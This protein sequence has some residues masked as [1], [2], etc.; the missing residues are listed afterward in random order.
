MAKVA[1]NA[2]FSASM[3]NG[4][5]ADACAPA[6]NAAAVSAMIAA[7]FN[8]QRLPARIDAGRV[9]REGF[10]HSL[11]VERMRQGTGGSIKERIKRG[12]QRKRR[13]K[14]NRPRTGRGRFNL[15]AARLTA[16]RRPASASRGS[17]A[18]S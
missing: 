9:L 13:L 6:E 11:Q 8:M 10:S 17:R 7:R 4:L 18:A 14:R 1:V 15:R 3:M 16:W 12:R 5:A 2:G